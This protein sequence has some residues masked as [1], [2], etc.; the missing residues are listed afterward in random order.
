LCGMQS[1]DQHCSTRDETGS[2]AAVEQLSQH[3]GPRHAAPSARSRPAVP[4]GSRGRRCRDVRRVASAA[5]ARPVVP[6]GPGWVH[7][8]QYRS[9]QRRAASAWPAHG[10]RSRARGRRRVAEHAARCRSCRVADGVVNQVGPSGTAHGSSELVKAHTARRGRPSCRNSRD[11]GGSAGRFHPAA[12]AGRPASSRGLVWDCTGTWGRGDAC[13]RWLG[14]GRGSH[15]AEEGAPGRLRQR[16]D[17][18]RRARR[19][20]CARPGP[21]WDWSQFMDIV[22]RD[23]VLRALVLGVISKFPIYVPCILL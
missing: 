20:P 15:T 14:A 5:R 4:K 3:V 8:R 7:G 12:R 9:V 22:W 13:G 18:T 1:R 17:S 21:M 19:P 2:K 16:G 6:V 23:A 10:P 11:A